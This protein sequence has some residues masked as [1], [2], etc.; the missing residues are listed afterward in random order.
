M[1][2]LVHCDVESRLVIFF[3]MHMLWDKPLNG[4]LFFSSLIFVALFLG[5]TL[6]DAEG[7]NRTKEERDTLAESL[8][9]IVAVEK[10]PA[11]QK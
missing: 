10:A 8:P 9:P 7:I 4:I 11:E 6:M 5:F 2:H 3:F 1:G